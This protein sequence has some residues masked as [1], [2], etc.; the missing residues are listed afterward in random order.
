MG[1]ILNQSSL[2]AAL[3]FTILGCMTA[4]GADNNSQLLGL[5]NGAKSC[6]IHTAEH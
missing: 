5:F 1:I 4:A 2:I 6:G 3:P